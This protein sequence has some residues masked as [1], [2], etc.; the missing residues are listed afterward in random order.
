MLSVSSQRQGYGSFECLV[1]PAGVLFCPSVRHGGVPVHV[2]AHGSVPGAGDGNE[3]RG[4]VR[5][6]VERFV[7]SIAEA[8]V[9]QLENVAGQGIGG[10]FRHILQGVPVGVTGE[11]D[12]SAAG[13][14]REDQG[15]L[16]GV[17]Q[18]RAVLR[19]IQAGQGQAVDH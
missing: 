19:G 12:F 4:C 8:V 7:P 15:E 16:V 10:V 11:Q 14:R 6:P 18:G 9:G 17:V 13:F 5:Q 2:R 1:Y 3:H